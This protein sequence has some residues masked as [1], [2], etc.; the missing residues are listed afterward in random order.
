MTGNVQDPR[1]IDIENSRYAEDAGDVDSDRVSGGDVSGLL[2]PVRAAL[3]AG[4]AVVLPGPPP[5]TYVVAATTPAVV[6]TAKG[7]PVS[8][9][10]ALWITGDVAWGALTDTLALD[11]TGIALARRLLLDEQVTL[12]VPLAADVSAADWLAPAVRDGYALLFGA[13]W[14]PLQAL[15]ERFPLLY[16]SSANRTGYAPATHAAAARAMFGP[17]IPVLD[18]DAW[19]PQADAGPRRAST[20]MLRLRRCLPTQTTP[21]SGTAAGGTATGGVVIGGVVMDLVRRGAQDAV[22]LDTAAY[23]AE[24]RRRYA[25]GVMVPGSRGTLRTAEWDEADA[26]TL[27]ILYTDILMPSFPSQELVT[28]GELYAAATSDRLGTFVFDGPTLVGAML[29]RIYP[30]SRVL[31]LGYLATRPTARGRGIGRMLLTDVLPRWRAR[32]HPSLIVAEIEDPRFH[33]ATSYGDPVARLRLYVRTG[34]RLMPMPYF[35]P[36]LR[37]GLRRVADMLL[38]CLDE[39]APTVPTSVVGM[40]LDEYFGER[41]GPEVIAAEPDYQALR[42]SL[43]AHDEPGCGGGDTAIPL[44]PLDRLPDVPRFTPTAAAA[45]PVS[46]DSPTVPG[47]SAGRPG[48]WLG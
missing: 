41:E 8:Q 7:R 34:A 23:L 43:R 17:H 47:G 48:E 16:V 45:V 36:V 37:P 32:A 2:A 10:V 9:E 5:L 13:C 24:L 6:N 20:T 12:L 40:F 44:W 46:R 1:D 3:T 18:A 31:L 42:G 27:D 39:A 19:P 30:R 15:C 14:K 4:S 11:T 29:G 22:H 38:I 25:S 35:Q 21:A 33:H 26:A 28:R